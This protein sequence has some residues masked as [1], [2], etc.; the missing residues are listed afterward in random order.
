MNQREGYPPALQFNVEVI[1]TVLA[2][3]QAKLDSLK[4]K[5]DE[6]QR[7]VE[8]L[9][10]EKEVLESVGGYQ[11][12]AEER[13]IF[14]YI[15]ARND[16]Y[17]LQNPFEGLDIDC[18]KERLKEVNSLLSQATAHAEKLEKGIAIASAD[19]AVLEKVGSFHFRSRIEEFAVREYA[20]P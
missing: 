9:R 13:S 14:N 4:R 7:E 8:Y 10:S 15:C 3:A 6:C 20:H 19:I 17:Q 18:I 12:R 11:A 2:S 16:D 1:R 5:K